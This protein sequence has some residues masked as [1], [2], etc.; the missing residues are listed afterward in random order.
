MQK[1][2][3]YIAVLVIVTG[4]AAHQA[5]PSPQQPAALLSTMRATPG[6]DNFEDSEF[7]KQAQRVCDNKDTNLSIQELTAYGFTNVQVSTLIQA[8][9][10]YCGKT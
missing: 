1:L 8:A 9:P 2:A 7:L 10:A 6:A 3:C 4:C 5:A